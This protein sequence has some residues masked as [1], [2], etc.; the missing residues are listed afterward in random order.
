[1]GGLL[2]DC[3]DE[4]SQSPRAVDSPCMVWLS[5]G[6]NRG[7]DCDWGPV[8]DELVIVGRRYSFKADDNLG[9]IT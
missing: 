1:V 5:E 3:T 7:A 2:L 4:P 8:E 9:L 6:H